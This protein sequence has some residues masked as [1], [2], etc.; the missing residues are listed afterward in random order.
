MSETRILPKTISDSELHRRWQAARREMKEH[1]IDFLIFQN[2]TAELPG[3][4]K[5]FTDLNFGRFTDPITVIFPVDDDMIL[6]QR[7]LSRPAREVPP[8]PQL[9]GVKKQIFVPIFWTS[10]TYSLTMDAERVVAELSKYKKPRIGWVGLGYIPASFY[11]Y[12]TEHLTDA[13]F[14]DATEIIDHLKAIKSDEEK[15]LIRE[16]CALQDKLWDYVLTIVKPGETDASIKAKILGKC[17]IW[18]AEPSILV[19]A[20]PAGVST[21]AGLG[22]GEPKIIQD[23][24]QITILLET[25]SPTGYWGE[26]S[27]TICIGRV[28]GRLEEQFEWAKEAQK[29]TR[30]LL[31][32][33]TPLKELWEANNSFMRKHGFPE[34]KR[35]YAHGQGYDIVERPCLDPE[36]PWKIEAHTFL[37]VHPEVNSDQA[38][39][40]ICDNYFVND[41]GIPEHF[42]QT[43]QKIFVI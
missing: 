19:M 8:L 23:G 6:I 39:G 7:T 35:I 18:G 36:D 30:D 10:L 22:F 43:P 15:E 9:R 27:R 40:L 11:K 16:T 4:V 1:N 29:L 2:S 28:P 42:H 3:N 41:K 14:T 13:I 12:V 5:W 32:P 34:E 26:I 17:A 20:A 24:F 37:A 21:K 25:S 38:N 31:R 33:G